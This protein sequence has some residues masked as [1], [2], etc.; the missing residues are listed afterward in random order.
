MHWVDV[1]GLMEA[2]K[3]FESITLADFNQNN[4]E[5]LFSR[6]QKFSITRI[7]AESGQTVNQGDL[8]FVVKPS[9]SGAAASSGANTAG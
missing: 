4:G 3:M 7:F 1:V 2:M 9:P 6:E 5:V 8:L